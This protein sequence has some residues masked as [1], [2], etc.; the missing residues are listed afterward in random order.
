MRIL[1]FLSLFFATTASLLRYDIGNKRNW[2]LDAFKV[3]LRQGPMMTMRH[4][5]CHIVYAP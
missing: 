3:S 4:R 1:Q 2:A 5:L